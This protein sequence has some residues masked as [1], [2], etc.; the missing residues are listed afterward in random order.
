[1]LAQKG[2]GRSNYGRKVQR[3]TPAAVLRGEQRRAADREIGYAFMN[4]PKVCLLGKKRSL[5]SGQDW[6]V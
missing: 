1:V 3:E 4:F 5:V 6:V 2:H